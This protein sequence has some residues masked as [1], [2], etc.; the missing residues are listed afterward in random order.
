MGGT[1]GNVRVRHQLNNSDE[2]S[3]ENELRQQRVATLEILRETKY[4]PLMIVVS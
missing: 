3:L 2:W 1:E 4:G